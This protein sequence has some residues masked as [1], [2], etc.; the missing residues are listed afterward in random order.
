MAWMR[1]TGYADKFSV[2]P[3]DSI[4]FYVNCDGPKEYDV[5][6]VRMVHC[7]TNPKGPGLIEVSSAMSLGPV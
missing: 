2:H 6:L 4:K 1:L 7:D 3:G 5:Q